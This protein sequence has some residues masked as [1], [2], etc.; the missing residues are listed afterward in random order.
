MGVVPGL[1]IAAGA[2]AQAAGSWLASR[3]GKVRA[4]HML[5]ALLFAAGACQPL[6]ASIQLTVD[7]TLPDTR[8]LALSWIRD[9]IPKGSTVAV[10]RYTPPVAQYD[11]R[12]KVLRRRDK[13]EYIFVSSYE[14]GRYFNADG[15]ARKQ[16][17]RQANDWQDFFNSHELLHEVAPEKNVSAGPVIRIYRNAPPKQKSSAPKVR[18]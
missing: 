2:A 1:A 13:P 11:K 8:W 6:P 3:T 10:G 7:K 14:Y 4:G 5:M 18:E 16:Y 15:T 17:G 12:L 9:N